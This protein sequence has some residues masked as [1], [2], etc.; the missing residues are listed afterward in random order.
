MVASAGAI[1]VAPRIAVTTTPPIRI[2]PSEVS[3][4]KGEYLSGIVLVLDDKLKEHNASNDENDID[5]SAD[6]VIEPK[7]IAEVTYTH[8]IFFFFSI[9]FRSFC[10]GAKTIFKWNGMVGMCSSIHEH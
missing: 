4:P 5:P 3:H 6:V 7:A 10:S 1:K 9:L 8:F 2:S